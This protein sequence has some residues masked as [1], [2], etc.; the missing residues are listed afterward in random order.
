MIVLSRV[1]KPAVR[2]IKKITPRVP[3]RGSQNLRLSKQLLSNRL[4]STVTNNLHNEYKCNK[5]NIVASHPVYVCQNCNNLQSLGGFE[6]EPAN[7][8]IFSFFNL[9]RSYDIDIDALNKK[10]KDL[11]RHLHPDLQISASDFEKREFER[12]SASVSQ[13]YKTLK[14]D[15]LRA[16]YMLEGKGIHF[17]EDTNIGGLLSDGAHQE[18]NMMLLEIFETREQIE[19]IDNPEDMKELIQSNRLLIQECVSALS[20]AFAKDDI[21]TATKKTILLKFLTKIDEES[22]NKLFELSRVK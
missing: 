8:D 20:E 15:Y 2:N 11:L 13:V 7:P 14:D 22:G 5:C 18:V 21:E 19:F 10:Y 12:Q 17:K 16:V 3:T 4:Y 9:K 6:S 1:L